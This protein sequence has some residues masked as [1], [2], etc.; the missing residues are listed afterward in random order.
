M[1][2][3]KQVPSATTPAGAGMLPSASTNPVP[4]ST[5]WVKAA[6]LRAG[7]NAT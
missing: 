4:G 3:N 5:N 1:A 6:S 7:A 2:C